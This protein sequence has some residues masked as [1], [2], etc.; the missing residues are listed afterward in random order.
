MADRN[1]ELIF[2]RASSEDVGQ[3][4]KLRIKQLLD[5]GYPEVADIRGHLSEYFSLNLE[6][7]SLMCWVGLA[8][9]IVRATDAI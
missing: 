3:L 5:E 2:R 9:E 6:N 1:N 8:D 7:E 4:V